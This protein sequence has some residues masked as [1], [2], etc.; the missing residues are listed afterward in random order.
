[1]F[2]HFMLRINYFMRLGK[3]LATLYSKARAMQKLLHT[4]F[5]YLPYSGFCPYFLHFGFQGRSAHSLE[6]ELLVS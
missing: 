3:G 6:L 5:F 4:L 1:M 2:P